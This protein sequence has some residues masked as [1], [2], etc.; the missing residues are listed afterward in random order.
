MSCEILDYPEK[1]ISGSFTV[2]NFAHEAEHVSLQLLSE[3]RPWPS[4]PQRDI[5]QAACHLGQ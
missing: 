1:R 5:V 4:G 3:T 2:F